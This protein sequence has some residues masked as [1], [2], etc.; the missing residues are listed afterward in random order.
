MACRYLECRDCQKSPAPSNSLNEICFR[1]RNRVRRIIKFTAGLVF[2]LRP[3]SLK[4]DKNVN[5]EQLMNEMLAALGI[6][7]CFREAK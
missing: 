4:L 1:V 2:E 5:L 7:Q 3:S 6:S